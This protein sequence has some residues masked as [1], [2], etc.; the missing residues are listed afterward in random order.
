MNL[1][2][3][4][5]RGNATIFF[6]ATLLPVNYYKSLLS[7][8][9]DNYAVYAETSFKEEQRLLLLGRDVSSKYTRRNQQE[10]YKIAS[11]I[12]K[13][14]RAK[15]GNYMVFFPS[16][17]MLRQVYEEFEY[18]N[19]GEMEVVIQEAGMKEAER[20]AFLEEFQKEREK[21]LVA[22]C[23]MGGIFGEGID[24]KKEQLI[25][26]LIVGTGLPQISNEREILK[27]YYDRRSKDASHSG[28]GFDYAYRYP[29]MN[30]VLQAAGRVIRTMDDVGV[31]ELLDERFLQSDYRNLFPREWEQRDICTL[32]N[33]EGYLN[34]FWYDK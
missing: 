13:T 30:K 12:K 9:Q 33:V 21:S 18:I 28:E 27:N 7:T 2:E 34:K 11:Y 22:F 8:K 10:F 29:G 26:A 32:E 19:A 24:L 15:C 14:G 16:Y 1:Q 25:G 20:E 23:V 3:C 5:D 6:S 4:L 17:K 31:I